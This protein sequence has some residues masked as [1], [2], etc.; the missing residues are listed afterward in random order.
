MQMGGES[1]IK[2]VLNKV[3]GRDFD[4]AYVIEK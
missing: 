2:S 1:Q 3:L 4:R